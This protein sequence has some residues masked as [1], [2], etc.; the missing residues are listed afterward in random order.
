[1]WVEQNKVGS[2]TFFVEETN[3]NIAYILAL[4]L[5]FLRMMRLNV[6]IT[7]SIC[8]SPHFSFVVYSCCTEKSFQLINALQAMYF[9]FMPVKMPNYSCHVESSYSMPDRWLC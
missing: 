3:Q 6:L 9:F 5:R 2:P 7:I 1:M 8:T 4:L